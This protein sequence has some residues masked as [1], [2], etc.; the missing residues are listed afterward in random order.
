LKDELKVK[1]SQMIRE[2]KDAVAQSASVHGIN[3]P[4]PEDDQALYEPALFHINH[5]KGGGGFLDGINKKTNDP[6][7][8]IINQNKTLNSKDWGFSNIEIEYEQL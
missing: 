3:S 6:I 4:E 1:I 5:G 7:R 8:A 2:L